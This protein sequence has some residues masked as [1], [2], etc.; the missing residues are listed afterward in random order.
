MVGQ[1]PGLV[2]LVLRQLIQSESVDWVRGRGNNSKSEGG[3][4]SNTAFE[5]YCP[6]TKFLF[7]GVNFPAR[8]IRARVGEIRR[9]PGKSWRA[10]L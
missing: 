9:T 6:S 5:R 4:H 3:S 1:E 10:R 2:V 7:F 8:K